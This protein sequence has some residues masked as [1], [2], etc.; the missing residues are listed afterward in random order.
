MYSTNSNSKYLP[1]TLNKRSMK[2][3]TLIAKGELQALH[4]SVYFNRFYIN[5]NEVLLPLILTVH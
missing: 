2:K 4:M 1:Q 5:H 3:I